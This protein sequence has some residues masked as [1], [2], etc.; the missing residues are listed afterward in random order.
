MTPPSWP[1]GA[2]CAV[3]L[4]FDNFGEALDLYRHGH[5]AGALADGVY[6]TRRGVGRILDLLECQG[7]TGTFFVEG[8]G[9][10]KYADLLREVARRGHEVGA[11]GWLH[12][13]WGGLAEGEQRDLV[14]RTTGAIG[15]ALGQA[16]R[17][18]RSPGGLMTPHTLEVVREAGYLYDSSFA[19][20][21]V[22]YVFE[23]K[24]LVELP[25][26]WA[27][28]DAPFYGT[29]RS[30]VSPSTLAA[31]WKEEF[32]AAHRLTGSFMVV[33]HP[34]FSG[35]PAHSVGL[36]S[37]IEH[38]KRAEGVWFARCE[39][40]AAHVAASDWAPRHAAPAVKDD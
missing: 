1:D 17:G 6:A 28:D 39:E 27:L 30:M 2:R 37:V 3:T 24:G 22:P 36:E 26:T 21:D 29:S 12:E 10:A 32:D 13:D 16:P 34:R 35:R 20:E 33:C 8:W 4:T 38:A 23:G 19:D 11:H 15:D 31:M 18:W 40:V 9:A 25:W 14:R 5:A 7:V